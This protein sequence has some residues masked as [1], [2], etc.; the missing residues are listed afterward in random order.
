MQPPMQRR[1]AEAAPTD[2]VR[3]PHSLPT[4]QGA[5]PADQA[6]Q[7]AQAANGAASAPARSAHPPR[8]SAP[9][10]QSPMEGPRAWH[11]PTS[12]R[13]PGPPEKPHTARCGPP[14]STQP[15]LTSSRPALRSTGQPAASPKA[16][17]GARWPSAKPRAQHRHRPAPPPPASQSLPDAARTAPPRTAPA[18][19]TS[20]LPP[21]RNDPKPPQAGQTGPSRRP[22][23]PPLRAGSPSR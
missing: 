14:A 11:L 21:P 19:P 8:A 18:L 15:E 9:T 22:R 10:L 13:A 5:M 20:A 1:P 3:N 16:P 4:A 6:F 7:P 2:S 12:Q 17:I 23:R